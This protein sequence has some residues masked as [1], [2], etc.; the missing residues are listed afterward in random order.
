MKVIQVTPG[1]IPIPP[2]GWGAVERI[3]WEYKLKLDELDDNK[4]L[5]STK[6]GYFI[7][8]YPLCRGE[9]DG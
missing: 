8:I 4:I 9:S 5:S 2:N 6:V 3:I 7:S 1:L